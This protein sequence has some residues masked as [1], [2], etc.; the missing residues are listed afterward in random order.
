MDILQETIHKLE[1]GGGMRHLRKVLVGLLLLALVLGYNW[2]GF[3]NMST[4]EAMDSAQLAHN[5]AS[6][7]GYSTKFNPPIQHVSGAAS[8]EAN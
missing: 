1:V 6:G 2:R 8:V 7:E 5:L 3:R 4:Q